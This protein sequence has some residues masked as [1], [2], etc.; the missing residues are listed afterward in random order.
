MLTEF[1]Q[2]KQYVIYFTIKLCDTSVHVGDFD[3]CCW[4]AN[5]T[6]LQYFLRYC[7]SV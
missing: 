5:K 6:V 7:F 3:I 1:L 2:L 4:F